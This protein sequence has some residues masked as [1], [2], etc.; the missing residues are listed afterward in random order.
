MR[1][2]PVGRAFD[3][4]RKKRVCVA[5]KKKCAA[6]GLWYNMNQKER[7]YH[8]R[9]RAKIHRDRRSCRSGCRGVPLIRSRSYKRGRRIH[10]HRLAQRQPHDWPDRRPDME[11]AESNINWQLL[12]GAERRGALLADLP[13]R[14]DYSERQLPRD[15][16]QRRIRERR[17]V[18]RNGAPYR[19]YR[20][21]EACLAQRRLAHDDDGASAHRAAA[22]FLSHLDRDVVHG[23]AE[24]VVGERRQRHCRKQPTR[25]DLDGWWNAGRIEWRLQDWR[26]R[27]PGRLHPHQWRQGFV[28]S[29]RCRFLLHRERRQLRF[30]AHL[31]RNDFNAQSHS[32]SESLWPFG[33]R[34][35]QGG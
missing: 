30:A 29:G 13:G 5:Q 32:G 23:G 2:C 1:R 21:G 10:I 20:A 27:Q 14:G 12:A 6:R 3:S 17:E 24:H 22:Q 15:E 9:E 8:E 33:R 16:G 34:F 7:I 25:D 35:E 18:D 31:R 19:P 4:L 28:G 11:R 26:H